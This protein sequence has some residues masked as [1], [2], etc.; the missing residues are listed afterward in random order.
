MLQKQRDFSHVPPSVLTVQ[1]KWHPALA[2]CPNDAAVPVRTEAIEP[3]ARDQSSQRGQERWGR[4][5]CLFT[6]A[7]VKKTNKNNKMMTDRWPP[8]RCSTNICTGPAVRVE[9]MAEWI[10]FPDINTQ[11]CCQ[12]FTPVWVNFENSP[13][14]IRC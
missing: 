6:D 12:L 8:N 7:R 1:T 13:N 2:R 9:K 4:Y 5:L 11:T 3:P 10:L 14:E